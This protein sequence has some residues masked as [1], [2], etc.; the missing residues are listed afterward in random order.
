MNTFI[1]ILFLLTLMVTLSDS[2]RIILKTVLGETRKMKPL[3]LTL[4]LI[5]LM[6][7]CLILGELATMMG[8]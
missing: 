7:L 3:R 5:S 1:E 2:V 4:E 6:G 8:V